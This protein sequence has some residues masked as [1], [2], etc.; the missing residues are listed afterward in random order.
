MK[1]IPYHILLLLALIPLSAC[2]TG[3]PAYNHRL[4]TRGDA[5]ITESLFNYKEKTIDEIQIRQILDGHIVLSDS[6]R[7]AVF[8]Y[9]GTQSRYGSWGWYDEENLRTQQLLLDTFS[10]ALSRSPKVQ[11][12]LFLPTMVTGLHPNI[13]QLRESAVRVQADM[14][15]IYS[16]HSDLFQKYRSFKKDEARA[17]ATCEVVLL[18][19]RTGII[20]HTNVVTKSAESTQERGDFTPEEHKRRALH[21]ATLQTLLEAGQQVRH[22]FD[23]E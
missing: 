14:L 23:T 21:L 5:T 13:H 17:F 9:G 3:R 12:V 16:L 15:L 7:L 10:D 2:E 20:P 19:T 11:K 4:E 22:F 8:Q 6:I 18:D 1:Q